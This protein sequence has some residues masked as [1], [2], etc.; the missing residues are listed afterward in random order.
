ML[1]EKAQALGM[2]NLE[3]YLNKGSTLHHLKRC[4]DAIACYDQAL[5][6]EPRHVD[7]HW[8]KSLLKLSLGE[9]AEGWE[10]YEWR[11]KT[12]FQK[13]AARTYD[14]P[15]WLG[16][17]PLD[18][19]TILV[20]AEQGL[21]DTIQFCRYI[22]KLA[23]LGA[24]VILEAPEALLR[25]LGSLEGVSKLI[26][27]GSSPP[28]F[29]YYCPLLSLPLAFKTS[30]T[31]IPNQVP[32]LKPDP[33]KVGYWKNLLGAKSHPRVGLVWSGGF[34][35]NQPELWD[36]NERR[37]IPLHKLAPLNLPNID[38]YSLQKGEEA[39]A[40]LTSLKSSGWNGPELIDH[41]DRLT[42]YSDT[43]AFIENLD[44][45]ISVDTSV[46]HMAGALGKPVWILNRF[47]TDWRWFLDRTDSPWYPSATIFNQSNPE[48][49]DTVVENVREKLGELIL[50]HN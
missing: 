28:P 21:G 25:I 29:D 8:N 5:K 22:T 31:N 4:S 49:W 32:Y 1:Y 44:L 15:L 14:Q 38:F 13:S 19:R 36:V 37:N 18:N 30:V 12:E 39:Q 48:D 50:S 24:K 40:M 17:Q 35:P 7:A 11:W 42:D 43:A 45:I 46:A 20:F 41:T 3:I 6:L 26:P 9:Y 23:D 10:L 27:M 47:D 33:E 34:R 16:N 2:Q